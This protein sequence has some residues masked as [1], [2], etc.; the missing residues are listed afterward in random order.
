MEPD[1]PKPFAS[2]QTARATFRAGGFVMEAEVRA[3]PLGLLAIG[4]MV[5]V[6]LLSVPPILR[7]GRGPKQLPAARDH[8][9]ES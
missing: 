5:A 4:G 9:P 1:R 7:A 3:T 6:I 8:N 2:P